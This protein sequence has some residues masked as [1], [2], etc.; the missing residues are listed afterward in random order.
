MTSYKPTA[1]PS[2]LV[3]AMAAIVEDVTPLEGWQHLTGSDAEASTWLYRPAC[4]GGLVAKQYLRQDYEVARLVAAVCRGPR[5]QVLVAEDEGG[6]VLIYQEAPGPTFAHL[7]DH[8]MS[9]AQRYE[10][11]A[12]YTESIIESLAGLSALQR[13]Q[14]TIAPTLLTALGLPRPTPESREVD[15][16]A[17]VLVELRNLLLGRSPSAD[18]DSSVFDLQT[19]QAIT[20]E[21]LEARTWVV[22][23]T[24]PANL[25]ATPGGGSVLVDVQLGLGVPEVALMPL[26]G[27]RFDLPAADV[28][29]LVASVPNVAPHR[30]HLVNGCFS[31]TSTFDTLVGLATGSRNALSGSSIQLRRVVAFSLAAAGY[32]FQ[33]FPLDVR[34]LRAIEEIQALVGNPRVAERLDVL[35]NGGA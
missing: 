20:V 31:V 19:E 32:H 10:I 15:S 29:N 25:I 12:S 21:I 6:S 9:R 16:L 1:P 4:G 34:L 17:R 5:Y 8:A 27:P 33:Q 2:E 11:G 26:G 18:V 13:P 24:N 14:R 7:L 3:D 30:W 28:E 35:Q 23:D 22:R